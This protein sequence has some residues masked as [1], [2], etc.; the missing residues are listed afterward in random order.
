MA[1]DERP[2]KIMEKRQVLDSPYLRIRS[3]MVELPNGVILPDYY[4]IENRGWVGIVPITEDGR[5]LLNNQYKH[6]IGTEVL[7]FPAGGIDEDE[8]DPLIAAHRE[9]MEESGYSTTRMEPLSEMVTNPTSA[10]A[11]AWWYIAYDIRK[12]GEQKSDPAEVIENRL[13]T[14]SELLQLIHRGQ[15]AVQGQIAAAYMALERLG[16]LHIN[17]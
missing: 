14:P 9:L 15:F 1:Q 6:G 16:Y 12:T 4:I 11:R 5:F 3:E 2:W 10:E 13:V 7:E 8:D 17:V